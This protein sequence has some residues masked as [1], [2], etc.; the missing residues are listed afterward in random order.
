MLEITPNIA[1]DENEIKIQFVQASGP[2]GQ[3]VNKVATSA[4][5]RFDVVNSPSLEPDIKERILSSARRRINK[6]GILIIEARRYRTQEQNRQDAVNR[7]VTIL[8]KSLIRPKKRLAT[9]PS[10]TSR[11]ARLSKKKRRGD[12]KKTRRYVPDEWE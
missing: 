12:I 4:Q 10:V 7:L 3:N 8:Q 6:E 9:R 1:I 2:G 11:A 5:L